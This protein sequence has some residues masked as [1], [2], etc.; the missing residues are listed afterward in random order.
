MKLIINSD[1]MGFSKGVTDGIISAHKKGVVTSCSIMATM[2]AFDYAVT[3]LKDTK[4]LDCGVHLTL[5]R[6]K[7]M[8]LTHKTI[9]DE[10]GFFFKQLTEDICKDFD[11]NE[12]YNEFVEQ[13]EK[14]KNS[15]IE[16]THFDSHHHVHTIKALQPVMEKLVKKYNL[17]TRGG[18]NYNIKGATI[19][20][21]IDTFYNNLVSIDYFKNNMEL[22]KSYDIVDIMTHP[23]FVD[24]YL[25]ENTSYAKKREEEYN[26]LTSNELKKLFKDEDI[27]LVSYKIFS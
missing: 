17:P 3:K 9:V 23:A 12:V 20:P 7:P 19:V 4:T 26:V 10:N 18:V 8:I 21:V 6:Y 24:D 13:I 16:I 2:P 15:K 25:L 22:I 5:S 27:E 14:V 1:D 11:M